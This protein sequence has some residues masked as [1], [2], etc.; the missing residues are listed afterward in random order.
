M[1]H[2]GP[3][4]LI[5]A[6][7]GT[8]TPPRR[9]HLEIC[10]R[11]RAQVLE[12]TGVLTQT[13]VA[14]VPEPSPLFWERLSDRV[15]ESIAT[16]VRTPDASRWL[17]QWL[18]WQVLAPISALALL[19]LALAASIPSP[20]RSSAPEVATATPAPASEAAPD[21]D[22]AWEVF[23]DLVGPLDVDAMHDAGLA[24]ALGA[25]DHVAQELSLPEQEALV[26]LLRE[27]LEGS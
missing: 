25:A 24:M 9:A 20:T 3:D 2:L 12:L 19:I 17:P 26:D 8:L 14:T 13:R 22:G 21:V 23:S 15:R 6:V 16:D 10:T 11:C 4:E 5:D 7:E 18:H 1:S 27:E